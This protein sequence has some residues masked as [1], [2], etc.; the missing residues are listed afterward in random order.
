MFLI[1]LYY[2]R[3][4]ANVN[5]IASN[6]PIIELNSG[7]AHFTTSEY[8]LFEKDAFETVETTNY[9]YYQIIVVLVPKAADEPIVLNLFRPFTTGAWLLII[10]SILCMFLVAKCT[11]CVR[12]QII[13]A[14][15]SEY[16]IKNLLL[17]VYG[18]FLGEAVNNRMPSWSSFRCIFGFWLLYS[19]LMT[20]SFSGRLKS[21]LVLPR[22]LDEIDTFDELLAT[23]LP[24]YGF[25]NHFLWMKKWTN[26]PI[27][28]K[29]KNRIGTA[30]EK[31]FGPQLRANRTSAYLIQKRE[32]PSLICSTFDF[33]A[34]R[35]IF[36]EMREAIISYRTVFV[37]EMGSPF[38]QRINELMSLF[39]QSGLLDRWKDDGVMEREVGDDDEDS[40]HIK[41]VITVKHLQMAFYIWAVGV[42]IS[43][44]VFVFELRRKIYSKWQAFFVGS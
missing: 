22:S 31:T 8:I 43:N 15:S 11:M 35:P 13:N 25:A 4:N 30:D 7:K 27:W 12:Q 29:I 39:R 19:L 17:Q 18:M 3:L 32:I 14:R 33:K 40:S 44:V 20:T 23:D 5:R 6:E 16:S 26:T 28:D 2:S 10:F 34:M 37:T 9:A 36:H 41:V 21:S 1:L 42:I 38:V 24:I